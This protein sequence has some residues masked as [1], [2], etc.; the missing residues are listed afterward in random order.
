MPQEKK[1][2]CGC[3]VSR[4]RAD[5]L[6]GDTNSICHDFTGG[7]Q[8]NDR[9]RLRR[10]S[11][12]LVLWDNFFASAKAQATAKQLI[13]DLVQGPFM[14]A[15]VQY[16]IGDG[17]LAN[18]IVLDTT[19]HP[20]PGNWDNG[21]EDDK[22]QVLQWVND[23]TISPKPV[24]DESSLVFFF[25]LPTTTT[26]TNGK[27]N[28]GSPNTNI[29]GWH[30]SQKFNGNSQNNDLFWGLVRTDGADK[31]SELN[32]VNSVAF[33]VGHELAEAFTDRDGGGFVASNGCEI[34]DL[35]ETKA[36]FNYRGWNVEQV[37]SNWNSSC[38][39]GDGPIS[40][41]QFLAAMNVDPKTGVRQLKL[42]ELSRNTM[43]AALP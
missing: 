17:V 21:S 19:T 16:G 25:F 27:N 12:V 28:D 33:C 38:V 29:C 40:L 35:C 41:K 22:N 9:R 43:A 34:G 30:K 39:R 23:G 37:W 5:A 18:T 32:F 6:T 42:S 14:N 15:L 3:G 8:P 26:I 13:T 2:P 11:I 31:S 1:K 36:F 24:V 10:P 4:L 7:L 20:A